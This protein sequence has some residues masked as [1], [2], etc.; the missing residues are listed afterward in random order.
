MIDYKEVMIYSD[1]PQT[2]P[3]CGSRTEII[4]DLSHINTQSQVDKCLNNKCD[5]EFVVENDN[6][7]IEL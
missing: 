6:E 2:C 5:N 7:L 1:Q 4:F 3:R